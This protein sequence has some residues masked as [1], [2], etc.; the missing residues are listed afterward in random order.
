[1]SNRGLFLS[2]KFDQLQ[3][4][5][6]F[7]AVASAFNGYCDMLI[8]EG[9]PQRVSEVASKLR[10]T[11]GIEVFHLT[12]VV[13]SLGGILGPSP[14]GLY[15]QQ[16]Y[17]NAQ[18]R[19]LYLLCQFVEVISS[20]SGAAI[21]L[22]L[23]DL[24]WADQASIEVVKQLILTSSSVNT[25]KQFYFLGCCHKDEMG[26][27]HP[28]YG[29]LLRVGCVGCSVTKVQLA[30]MS[31]DT[32]NSMILQLLCLSPRLVKSLSSIVYHK[33]KGNPL[34]VSQVSPVFSSLDVWTRRSLP[35]AASFSFSITRKFS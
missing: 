15:Y 26:S 5:R 25:S 22:F 16:D 29:M 6:P 31:E 4:A 13:P 14:V 28:L 20:S 9:G 17:V 10:M 3:Q 21:T 2:G 33:T 23:D 30:C 12:N 18:R 35:P 19:I 27:G 34:F 32:I 1:V 8:R 11:L 7:S 24:Q